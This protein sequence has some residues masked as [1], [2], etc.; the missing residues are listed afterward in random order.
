MLVGTSLWEALVWRE[1]E[2]GDASRRLLGDALRF[3]AGANGLPALG[4]GLG[5]MEEGR[6]A[7]LPQE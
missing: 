6:G 5:G 4:A 7:A 3:I 1:D 2:L